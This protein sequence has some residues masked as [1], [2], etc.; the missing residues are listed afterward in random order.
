MINNVSLAYKLTYSVTSEEREWKISI[1][2]IIAGNN[3]VAH[4]WLATCNY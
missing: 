2:R 4:R 1:L 3:T